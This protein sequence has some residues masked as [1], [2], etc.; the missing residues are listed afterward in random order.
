[1][2]SVY[3]HHIFIHFPIGLIVASGLIAMVSFLK[4]SSTLDWVVTI[5]LALGV[6]FGIAAAITGLLSA[7]HLI[8]E[9][10]ATV[11]QV[12]AHRN[13]AILSLVLALMGVV[14]L[15]FHL[16]NSTRGWLRTIGLILAILAGI[17]VTFAGDRGGKMIH[18]SLGLFST[19]HS[20]ESLESHHDSVEHEHSH[21]GTIVHEDGENDHHNDEGSVDED[22]QAD[23]GGH[24]QPHD[25]EH[26]H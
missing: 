13:A 19:E 15:I 26:S 10:Q 2:S 11:G 3:L 7:D 8:E 25:D 23:N 22:T 12:S 21:G 24:H 17:A 5:I 6:S 4:R 20:H 14:S 9:G 1:M 16:R 18:P